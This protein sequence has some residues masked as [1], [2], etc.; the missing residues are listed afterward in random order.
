MCAN[1]KCRVDAA[2]LGN[3]RRCGEVVCTSCGYRNRRGAAHD[4]IFCQQS[5]VDH[6]TSVDSELRRPG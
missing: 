4:G 2:V 3:C 1:P 5:G 6:E